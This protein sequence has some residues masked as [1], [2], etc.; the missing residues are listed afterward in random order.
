[1]TSKQNCILR[2]EPT[3]LSFFDKF[4]A[5]L[6]LIRQQCGLTFKYKGFEKGSEKLGQHIYSEA[7][8]QAILYIV[9][10]LE[11][12]VRYLAIEAETQVQAENLANWFTELLPIISLQELQ[13]LAT[14]R[15][16]EDPQSLIRMALST[17]Q[18]ADPVSLKVIC[19][20]LQSDDDLVRFRAAAAAS[21]TQWSDFLEDLQSLRRQ[22]S[23]LEVTEMVDLAIEACQQ[24]I[25]LHE[26]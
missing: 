22:D 26:N 2:S 12:P 14:Q 19:Q 3:E 6:N 1:M 13:E 8:K 4:E 17:G 25:E 21:L 18:F 7:N 24:K 9:E 20:G 15:M 11:T 16:V 5:A 23:S 10:D